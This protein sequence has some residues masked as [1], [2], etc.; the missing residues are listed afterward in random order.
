MSPRPKVSRPCMTKVPD[1]D[2]LV[3]NAGTAHLNGFFEQTAQES[4]CSSSML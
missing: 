1:A 3:N 4:T 2:I